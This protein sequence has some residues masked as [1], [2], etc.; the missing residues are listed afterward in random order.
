MTNP[1]P[2]S[3]FPAA[4]RA[5]LASLF[6]ALAAA[7][8]S[9][10]ARAQSPGAPA[11]PPASAV[12]PDPWPKVLKA[13]TETFTLY[14]PQLDS[15]DQYRLS[16]HGAVSV[17]AD[18]AK[19]PVYGV[20]ELAAV[21]VVD[22]TARSVSFLYFG[23][24]Q[25]T[26]RWAPAAAA[27]Y[28][29][30][31]QSALQ[32]GPSTMSLDRLEQALRVLGAEKKSAAVP[33]RNDPPRFVF[34]Q[35][36]AMLVLVDGDPVWRPAQG[37]KLLRLLNTRALVVQDS[38]G[39]SFLNLW[40]G[41]MQAASLAGPWTVAR[42]APKGA[43]ALAKQLAAQRTVDLLEGAPDDETKKLPSLKSGPP[44]LYVATRPTELVVFEGAPDYVPIDGTQLLY[45]ANTTGNVFVD[46]ASQSTFVLVTGR[47]FR[48][49]PSK[50]P[51]P[52]CPGSPSPP[53]SPVCRTAAPRRT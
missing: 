13:G 46:M 19:E 21:T 24:A 22:R 25:A 27:R 8:P 18:G 5:V 48:A 43:D 20:V 39:T 37:T 38:T 35:V 28:G 51:G 16:A 23:V 36:P 26:F 3:R 7:A 33:V 41:W 44:V 52:T 1:L 11:M 29:A 30:A 10:L 50:A 9:S 40:D 47:W 32:G 45:A 49:P 2:R 15:W 31:I 4:G 53:T 6:L 12:T 34:S 17:L 42:K 14:E